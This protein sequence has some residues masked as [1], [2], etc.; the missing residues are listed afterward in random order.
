MW[1]QEPAPDQEC[2][3]SEDRKK[4]AD[5]ERNEDAVATHGRQAPAT[6]PARQGP[7]SG[8][9]LLGDREAVDRSDSSL[10]VFAKLAGEEGL[11]GRVRHL[12]AP[13]GDALAGGQGGIERRMPTSRVRD[14][15]RT[16]RS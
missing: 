3:A 4:Q 12:R 13:I 16:R 6:A 8:E 11:E 1:P 15:S 2:A 14:R 7:P 5:Q 9:R 10:G